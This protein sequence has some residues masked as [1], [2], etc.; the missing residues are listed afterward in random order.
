MSLTF[1]VSKNPPLSSATLESL[2]DK[3]DV[4]AASQTPTMHRMNTV[5][6]HN[7]LY[8]ATNPSNAS[9][10]NLSKYHRSDDNT[11][12][13]VTQ[14]Y[15][16][17]RHSVESNTSSSGCVSSGSLSDSLP[18]V[19]SLL[20]EIDGQLNSARKLCLDQDSLLYDGVDVKYAS[21]KYGRQKSQE[22][23]NECDDV[24]MHAPN[25]RAWLE[26]AS[27]PE[28]KSLIYADLD[29]NDDCGQSEL[30]TDV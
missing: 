9:K 4:I 22:R 5:T 13:D 7:P 25:N 15:T 14:R 29:L 12:D 21:D 30:E 2:S 24:I 8:N 27:T 1:V 10:T 19:K 6:N 18:D 26:K 3:A 16:G 23:G 17:R 20:S 11:I 28:K